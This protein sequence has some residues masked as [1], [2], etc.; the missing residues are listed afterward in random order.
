MIGNELYGRPR[1]SFALEHH[2]GETSGPAFLTVSFHLIPLPLQCA[3][4][5][6]LLQLSMFPTGSATSHTGSAAA[7]AYGGLLASSSA[8]KCNPHTHHVGPGWAS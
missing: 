5:D 4:T 6:A 2:E 1:Q 8:G 7:T 3:V